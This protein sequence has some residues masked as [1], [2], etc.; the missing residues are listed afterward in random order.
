MN[1]K[2]MIIGLCFSMGLLMGGTVLQA[3]TNDSKYLAGAVP[4]V[5]G[6]VVFSKEY[7]IP[8]MNRQEVFDRVV[9][10]MTA[11]LEKN[12]NNSRVVLQDADKGHVVGV[13]DEW[14]IF[15][16]TALSLDRTRI[17]YQL[18]VNCE[19]ELCR[20]EV[21]KVSF[22]YREGKE[23]YAAE[24]WVVDKYA[25][26]KD[27]SKLIRGLAK[28]R[29]KTVDFVDELCLGLA[30][31]LSAATPSPEELT[32][33]AKADAAAAEAAKEA[34]SVAASGAMTIVPHNQISTT[35]DTNQTAGQA[36]TGT[37]ATQ[38]AAASQS[39]AT[40]AAQVTGGQVA[41]GGLPPVDPHKKVSSSLLN[42]S[43]GRLVIVIG[44]D[45]FNMTMMTANA[46]GSLGTYQG[47]QVIF[48]ILSP[49]QAYQP[50]EAAEQYEVRFYPNG[51][52]EPSM[53]FR[54]R[55]VQGPAPIDGMPRTYIG[56]ILK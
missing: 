38:G 16:S 35:S 6:K 39:A 11:R 24:E 9:N 25:L 12:K 4:E 55:K 49:D 40:V 5:N 56:E 14:I 41:C 17:L 43:E 45:P 33:Q 15:S 48:T 29:R 21:S 22:I 51:S 52:S 3:Q 7:R 31:A 10:W 42:P 50:I 26:S 8:G 19:A 34:R 13:G 1:A 20:L 53:T 27:K 30:D 36:T 44:T 32:A 37:A 54:C 46:G 2:R 18:F 23:R 47:K 28:W